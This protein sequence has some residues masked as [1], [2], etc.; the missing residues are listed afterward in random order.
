MNP[1]KRMYLPRRTFLHGAL[2]AMLALPLHALAHGSAPLGPKGGRL[3]PLSA[4]QSLQG[5]VTFK[6]GRFFV[7]LLDRDLK[8]VTLGDQTLSVVGGDRSQPQRPEVSR[9]GNRFVFPAL[10]GTRYLLVLQYRATA[11]AKPVNARFEYDATK[12]GSCQNPEWLC[13]CPA[14]TPAKAP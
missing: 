1:S 5:E 12:C 4:D 7:E 10:K 13:R 3:V 14:E 11:S 2:L 8:P 6:E 9:D